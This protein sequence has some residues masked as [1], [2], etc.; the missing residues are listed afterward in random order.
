[1]IGMS[2]YRTEFASFWHGGELPPHCWICLKSFI[3]HGHGLTLYCYHDIEVPAGVQVGD[4][5]EVLPKTSIFYYENGPGAGSISAFSNIFRYKLLADKGGWWVDVDVLCMSD[6]LPQQDIVFGWESEQALGTAVLKL[7]LGHS[8]SAQ[9]FRSAT[10]IVTTRGS[11]LEWGEIGPRLFLKLV[12]ESGLLPLASPI[13][14]FY[15]IGWPEAHLMLLP[16]HRDTLLERASKSTF[17]HLWNEMFR[18]GNFD[19]SRPSTD[20]FLSSI[21]ARYRD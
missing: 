13:S 12:S 18:R 4:A 10:E 1:M 14:V 16:E 6:G 19:L 20:S 11:E 8:L 15:P 2:N 7:P 21:F 5:E 17:L 9:L 3:D